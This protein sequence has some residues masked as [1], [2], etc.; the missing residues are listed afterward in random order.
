MVFS[1]RVPQAM[2]APDG[3]GFIFFPPRPFQIRFNGE[4]KP[5]ERKNAS[6]SSVDFPPTDH[7]LL[8]GYLPLGGPVSPHE[9]Q[10]RKCSIQDRIV[11]VQKELINHGD[12][13]KACA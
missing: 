7:D 3:A 11:V 8:I 6:K 12:I 2:P 5:M 13:N 4:S 10:R 1:S 9:F